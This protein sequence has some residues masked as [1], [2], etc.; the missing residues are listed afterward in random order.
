MVLVDRSPSRPGT[1]TL[2]GGPKRDVFNLVTDSVTGLNRI[3]SGRPLKLGPGCSHPPDKPRIAL[4][5]SDPSARHRTIDLGAGNDV[6]VIAD[7][8]G[9]EGTRI[10]AGA[11]DDEIHGGPG[12]ELIEAGE[13]ADRLFGGGGSDGLVGGI[14]GRD[15]LSG[16][17]AGDLLAAGGPCI[18]GMLRGGDGRDNASFAEA[19][20]HPGVMVASLTTHRAYVAALPDCHPVRIDPS[21]EDL[22]GSF[23]WDILIGDARANSLLGQPGKDRFYG[24]GG[25]DQINAYDRRRDFFIDCGADGGVVLGDKR[26]PKAHRCEE[27]DVTGPAAELPRHPPG[28]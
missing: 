19:P 2:L 6:L 13:G 1:L 8:Q 15:F 26:D 22:E 10:G 28:R 27:G 21:D 14:P 11:G 3:R 17:D 25:F 20:G 16:Q 7:T 23:D 5:E 4:C 9:R 24:L 12:G 18:G